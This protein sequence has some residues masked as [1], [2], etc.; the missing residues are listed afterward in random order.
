MSVGWGSAT[1]GISRS[2]GGTLGARLRRLP[3]FGLP[4]AGVRA[5]LL[6]SN[7]HRRDLQP[8]YRQQARFTDQIQTN[9]R[10]AGD[11]VGVQ[12]VTVPA[13]AA[14]MVRFRLRREGLARAAPS[15]RNGHAAQ[16]VRRVAV[17]RKPAV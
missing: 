15:D 13:D 14:G 4:D 11:P 1:R 8:E 7:G 17:L 12:L 5:L 3:Q 10:S 6:G 9:R 16:H 2:D